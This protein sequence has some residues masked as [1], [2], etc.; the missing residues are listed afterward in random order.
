MTQDTLQTSSRT[1]RLARE[2][3]RVLSE[4]EG[5]AGFAKPRHQEGLFSLASDLLNS[6]EG[7]DHL[8]QAAPRFSEAGV[9]YGGPW[10]DPSRLVPYLVGASLKGSG[11]YPTVESLSMLRMVSLAAGHASDDRMPRGEAQTFLGDVCAK[12]VEFLLT[13]SATEEERKKPKL[14]ARARRVFQ[15]VVG[16]VEP[17]RVLRRIIEEVELLAAQRPILTESL[18]HLVREADALRDSADAPIEPELSETLDRYMRS[19]AAATSMSERAGDPLSYRSQLLKQDGDTLIEESRTFSAHLHETGLASPYHAVLLRR[20]AHDV[21]ERIG[22]ALCLSETGEAEANANAELLRLVVGHALVPETRYAILGL[23]GVLERS[24]LSRTEVAGGLRKIADLDIRSEVKEALLAKYSESS[25][26]T[27]NSVLLAGCL[28]ILGQPLG[29]GQGNNPTCQSARGIS[30]WS[31][32]A[33]GQL[34]SSIASVARDGFYQTNFEGQAIR[35]DALAGGVA[36]A[37]IEADL[38]PVSQ[39]LV[40]HLDRV[41]DHMMT[42]AALRADDGHRWVNRGLY[43]RWIQTGFASAF[44]FNTD[45][46]HRFESFVRRFY[47]THHPDHNDGH[48]LIYPNPVGIMVTDSHGRLLGRHAVS[49]QRIAK[50]EPD[51]DAP[52]ANEVEPETA[53]EGD[54][55]RVYFFNPN[56]EGRQDWGGGVRPTVA[57]HGELPGESS[58]PFDHFNSRLY[59]FHYDPQEQGDAFAVPAET[60]AHVTRLASESWGQAMRSF[61]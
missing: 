14:F 13:Q 21:P 27:A 47:A 12:N 49:I 45:A 29:I 53:S 35:S 61:A 10:E 28:S 17:A 3:D 58:L 7:V 2:F 52:T 44:E 50:F 6:D 42:L 51:A 39:V 24:L 31:Q 36:A 60:V 37:G 9:F 48:E 30:L 40:P 5:A 54:P 34:L 1:E 41:Y 25:G 4:M 59:A 18:E 56:N 19:S 33:P 46:V 43:G 16:Q 32:H 15:R 55:Y 57:H 38:D 23:T 22:E 26:A 11:V 20:I 8:L